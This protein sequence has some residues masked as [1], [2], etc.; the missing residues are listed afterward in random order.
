M[1]TTHLRMFIHGVLPAIS[2]LKKLYVYNLPNNL[3]DGN[4]LARLIPP[5][6]AASLVELHLEGS[7]DVYLVAELGR[8]SASLQKLTVTEGLEFYSDDTM[9]KLIPSLREL[10]VVTAAVP[11]D[12]LLPYRQD[13]VVT[14]LSLTGGHCLTLA[15][16]AS[17]TSVIFGS[18]QLDQSTW[19]LLP[20]QLTHLTCGAPS[21]PLSRDAQKL[22]MLQTL[23]IHTHNNVDNS[24]NNSHLNEIV[25]VLDLCPSL[26]SMELVG[27]GCISYPDNG[28]QYLRAFCSSATLSCLINL[29]VRVE[30]GLLLVSGFNIELVGST[31]LVNQDTDPLSTFFKRIPLGI[32]LCKRL[33]LTYG[34]DEEFKIPRSLSKMFPRMQ[35]LR[36]L[37]DQVFSSTSFTPLADCRAL[38]MLCLD[39]EAYN[40]LMVVMVCTCIPS[41]R[42]LQLCVLCNTSSKNARDAKKLLARWK[43]S[44]KVIIMCM[45]CDTPHV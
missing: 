24:N 32:L 30:L 36:I 9:D 7:V 29:N 11:I 14:P 10:T 19:D 15:S 8:R 28:Q 44:V 45:M 6:C 33:K 27:D 13:I 21:I 17:L 41:L 34:D 23:I 38:E 31:D 1:H 16:C 42:V 26:V 3:N 43:C 25:S 22:H 39:S 37:T 4:A 12:Q 5:I 20:T 18:H 2:H 40:R 35:V